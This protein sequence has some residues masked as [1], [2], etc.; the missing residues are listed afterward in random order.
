METNQLLFYKQ[1]NTNQRNNN[2]SLI[3]LTNIRIN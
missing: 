2:I 1:L 3:N